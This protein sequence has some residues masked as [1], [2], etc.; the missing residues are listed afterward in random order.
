MQVGV[1]VGILLSAIVSFIVG[2]YYGQPLHW[3]LFILLV[4]IGVFINTIILILKTRE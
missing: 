1:W 2:D 3:Y 4:F